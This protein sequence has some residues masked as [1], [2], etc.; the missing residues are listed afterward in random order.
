MQVH[1]DA[2]R[3]FAEQAGELAK[4]SPAHIE[5]A[6]TEA[7]LEGLRAYSWS[8]EG[9][10]YI[11]REGLGAARL[12]SVSERCRA[13]RAPLGGGYPQPSGSGASTAPA[14]S[15]AAMGGPA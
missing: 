4:L 15:N 5:A 13:L 1:W 7:Y 2:R 12:R 9:V 3:S 10:Q 11:G 14:L 6:L 8:R